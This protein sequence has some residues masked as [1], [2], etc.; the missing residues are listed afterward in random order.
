MNIAEKG[1]TKRKKKTKIKRKKKIKI[2]RSLSYGHRIP[3]TVTFF[4]LESYPIVI[5][6]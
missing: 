1:K 4:P 2:G 3:L 5:L 6:K